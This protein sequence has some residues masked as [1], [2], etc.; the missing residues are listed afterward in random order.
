MP[1]TTSTNITPINFGMVNAYLIKGIDQKFSIIDCGVPGSEGKILK[2]ISE[3]GLNKENLELIIITHGHSD[4]MGTCSVLRKE[5]GAKTIIHRED[6]EAIQKGKMQKLQAN[7]MVGKL[8]GRFL[9]TDIKG[10]VP[11]EPEIIAD[12]ELPLYEYG[13]AGKVIE[14]PGHTNG[15]ISVLLDDGSLFVGDLI[16]GGMMGKGKP[17]FPMWADSIVDIK[18]SIK[19]LIKV[20]PKMIYVGHGGPFTYDEVKEYFKYKLEH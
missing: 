4:H 3:L 9:G 6:A 8:I 16:Q 5:T 18:E 17:G 2:K 11:Y 19:Q 12:K 20:S 7:N 1:Q 13:I 14:T 10:F 15:S